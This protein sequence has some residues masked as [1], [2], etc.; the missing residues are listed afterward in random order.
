MSLATYNEARPWA[1]AIKEQT[2]NRSMPPWG[3]VKGY[4]AF[5]ND[6]GLTQ[7]ELALIA[8]WVEGGA[9]LG[10]TAFLAEPAPAGRQTAPAFSRTVPVAGTMKLPKS[11]T[12][13]GIRPGPSER[14]AMQMTARLPDGRV[15]PLL[16]LYGYQQRFA[17]DFYLAMPLTLPAGTVIEGARDV[18][19]LVNPG[20]SRT[21]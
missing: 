17:H 19:L 16:W 21:R 11:L 2:L 1:K 13:V 5:Q 12:V 4:G 7:A 18:M 14:E 6:S 20:S 8:E 9:P 15:E 10:D 3:A